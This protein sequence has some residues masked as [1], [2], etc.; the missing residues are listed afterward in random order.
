M[1]D[2]DALEGLPLP[3]RRQRARGHERARAAIMAQ[4]ADHRLPGAILLHG[5]QGI[6]KA[7]FAFELAAA[8]LTATGDEEAHRVEEQVAALSHPNLFVLRRRMK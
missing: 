2:P 1:S 3:E 8:I 5:P 7:T 4:I 6:G